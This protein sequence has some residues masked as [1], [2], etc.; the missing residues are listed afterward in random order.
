MPEA[1]STPR[2]SL[3]ALIGKRPP[4]IPV[5]HVENPDHAEPLAEA[6]VGGGLV[7]LE[8]TLR[9]AAALTVVKRMRKAFPEA[10]IGVGTITKPEQFAQVR[11]A[12]AQFGVSPALTDRL[13]AAS[14]DVPIPFIAGAVT[15]SEM[16][17]AREHGFQELKFFPAEF[18]GGIGA[19][20]HVLPL[21]PELR[22]CPTGGVGDANLVD[23]LAVP[24]CFAVGGAWLAPRDV[25][26]AAN[27]RDIAE[28]AKRAV[29]IYENRP[30][31]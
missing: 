6:L 10:L 23:F 17:I 21:F 24:N 12:G 18:F 13:A 4:L 26:E 15:P 19:L 25:I 1:S 30:K 29:G 7:A 2:P 22:F 11:D 20:K 8:V 9:S 3:A 14:L 5:L 27:W 28:R 31:R 16:L